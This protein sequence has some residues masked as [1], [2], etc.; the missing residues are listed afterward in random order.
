MKNRKPEPDI[1]EKLATLTQRFDTFQETHLQNLSALNTINER[2]KV[3]EQTKGPTD[4]T[5][6]VLNMRCDDL[7]TC[8][9]GL[10]GTFC[11]LSKRVTALERKAPVPD[12]ASPEAAVPAPPPEM[13]STDR[14]QLCTHI[15][16]QHVH[17]YGNG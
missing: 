7:G 8:Y 13:A 16:V 10:V 4:N 14:T 9:D 15:G 11:E 6:S 12:P 17:V 3:L 5:A 2:L 1:A